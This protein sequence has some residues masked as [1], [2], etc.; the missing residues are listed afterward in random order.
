MHA[1]TVLL[2]TSQLILE[3]FDLDVARLDEFLLHQKV[4]LEFFDV[5]TGL[6]RVLLA[7]LQ[8]GLQLFLDVLQD[9]GLLDEPGVLRL[10]LLLLLVELGLQLLVLRS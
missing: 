2:P 1:L 8:L 7:C 6:G 9:S 3:L 4:F 5:T 10:V